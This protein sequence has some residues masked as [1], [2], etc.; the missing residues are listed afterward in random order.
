MR[1]QKKNPKK[2]QK[3]KEKLRYF[4]FK[5]FVPLHEKWKLENPT[6]IIL[7][8]STIQCWKTIL[9]SESVTALLKGLHNKINI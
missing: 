9:F 8:E 7:C 2:R 4:D 6:L 3:F 1:I 5:E